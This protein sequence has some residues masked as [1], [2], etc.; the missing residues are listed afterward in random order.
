VLDEAVDFRANAVPFVPP[1]TARAGGVHI[2]TASVSEPDPG[3]PMPLVP[4]C[5]GSGSLTLAVRMRRLL[6]I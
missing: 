4:G 1:C 6:A 2:R 3:L 5:S